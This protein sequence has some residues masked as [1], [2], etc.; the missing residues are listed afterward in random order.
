VLSLIARGRTSREIAAELSLSV[1]TIG[2]HITNIYAK[3]GA[4]TRAD[5]TAYAI[6]HGLT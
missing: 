2:R 4:R 6:H 3:I 5:A 1:R